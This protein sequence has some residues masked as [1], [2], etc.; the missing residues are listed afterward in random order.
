MERPRAGEKLDSGNRYSMKKRI[1]IAILDDH[2]STAD[3]YRMR[4]ERVPG[5]EVVADVMY[6]DDVE[7]LL[8]REQ[9]DV[10][11]LDVSA[12]TSAQNRNRYPILHLIPRLLGQFPQLCILVITMH[13]G[14]A[15]ARYILEAGATCYILKDDRT[16]IENLPAIVAQAL[17]GERYCSPNVERRLPLPKISIRER[18]ALSL[19]AAYPGETTHQLAQRM[20]VADSTVRNLLSGAYRRLRVRSRMAAVSEARRLGVITPVQMAEEIEQPDGSV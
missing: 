15:L 17:R 2:L 13:S 19:A 6:G 20:N 3:G 5:F 18:E 9:I 4:F 1:R 14:A 8:Q 7:P 11:L 16:A 12:P 10:L